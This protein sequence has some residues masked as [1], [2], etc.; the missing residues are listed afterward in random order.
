MTNPRC[1]ALSMIF[2]WCLIDCGPCQ[3][4]HC[5]RR[6]NQK[7]SLKPC[8]SFFPLKKYSSSVSLPVSFSN[9]NSFCFIWSFIKYK[10][11]ISITFW[12]NLILL[13]I[14]AIKKIKWQRKFLLDAISKR[15]L[16]NWN[17][18]L[19]GHLPRRFFTLPRWNLKISKFNQDFP[20]QLKQLWKSNRKILIRPLWSWSIY[21]FRQF[22]DKNSCDTRICRIHN[23]WMWN[24][25]NFMW[26]L[27][28]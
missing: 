27:K 21:H 17:Y 20:L 22:S 7:A 1:C 25:F 11:I 12:I 3:S 6:A 24:K 28:L 26:K 14:S 4:D 2:N 23:S 10:S 19:R 16:L 18:T 13:K 9:S 15:S 8:L 5:S